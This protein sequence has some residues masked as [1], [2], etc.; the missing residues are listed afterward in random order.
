MSTE[1]LRLPMVTALLI[2]AALAAGCG[3]DKTAP[4]QV[5]PTLV[6]PSL[7]PKEPPV[8][9]A[10]PAPSP[11][12]PVP[13]VPGNPPGKFAFQ[14]VSNLGI[15]HDPGKEMGGG[16]WVSV[17]SDAKACALHLVV[18]SLKGSNWVFQESKA[19][20]TGY[21][22]EEGRGPSLAC[23]EMTGCKGTARTDF[24]V[25]L[26]TGDYDND[27]AT[28]V[29]VSYTVPIL[30]AGTGPGNVRAAVIAEVSPRISFSFAD[31]ILFDYEGNYGH[32]GSLAF[33]DLNKDGIQDIRIQNTF[34]YNCTYYD[35]DA[36]RLCKKKNQRG[37]AYEKLKDRAYV[38]NPASK[39]FQP[40]AGQEK[41]SCSVPEQ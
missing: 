2:G 16:L 6:L 27:R 33:E 39:T 14:R 29:M 5:A 32:Q 22:E 3:D 38:W 23:C 35:N 30:M 7:T 34:F 17:V 8:P 37:Y 20:P 41:Y 4:S 28:E 19:L 36:Y 9:E 31:G 21:C 40:S 12:P 26:K 18:L 24:D 1:M 15:A 10:P 11:G 25:E 13:A